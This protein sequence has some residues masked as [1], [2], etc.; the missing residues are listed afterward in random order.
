MKVLGKMINENTLSN[1]STIQFII[2]DF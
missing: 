2:Q 1:E